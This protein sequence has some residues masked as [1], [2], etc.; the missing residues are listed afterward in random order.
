MAHKNQLF[1]RYFH[2]WMELYKKGAVRNVTYQKYEMTHKHI[3]ALAPTLT[4]AHLNRQAYQSL[5]NDFAVNHERLTTM[6]LHHHLKAAILDAIDEGLIKRD[7]TRKAVIKGTV[8][9]LHKVKF[10]HQRELSK[11]LESLK[12]NQNISWD[13]FILLIA[14]TGLRF[15]EAL[16]LTPTDFNF[17][18]QRLTINKTWDYKSQSSD[19]APTKNR[20]SIR[21]IPLDWHTSMQFSQL[22]RDLPKEKPIFIKK[23][24][25]AYNETANDHLERLCKRAEVPVISIHGLRHTH[26]SLLLY[27][28]VSVASVA[29]RLGHA[30]MSTTQKT[31]LHIIQ[32]LE[33]Q[34]NDKI[35]RYLTSLT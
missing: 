19:F 22:I 20:S 26:A 28:G 2:E 34:D 25:R 29:K 6:D 14:K 27:A 4:L 12:L 8:Q 35:M 7:P 23:G 5:L 3:V 10:L 24:K 9:R 18:E 17:S 15:G 1:H 16:G 30:N 31:Y 33:N 11:L 32:E 13:Y 21:K